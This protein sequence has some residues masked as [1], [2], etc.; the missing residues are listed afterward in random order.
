[1]EKI[2]MV[3]G[4]NLL[5]RSYYATAYTGNFMK[6]SKGFP[7]NALYGFINMINKIINEENPN[8]MIVAFDK[9][10]TFRHN[11]YKDYKG[12]RN[13]TPEELKLQFPIAKEI[14]TSM[15]IKYYEIDNYE[16][17]DI[18]GTFSSYCEKD[19][20]YEGL[21]VSSDKDLLQLVSDEV[22]IKL[23]KQKDFIKYNKT[24]FIEEYGIEP[25]KI[26]DL[27]ALMGD[28]S[29]SIPGVKGIGEKTA[30]KLL[31]DY[32]SLDG[33]YENIDKLTPKMQEKLLSEKEK[34]YLSFY[35][36]TIIK[37]VPMEIDIND[38]KIKEKDT[39]ELNQLYENLEFYSLLKKEKNEVKKDFSYKI[40]KDINMVSIDEPSSIYIELSGTNYHFSKILGIS[41]SNS[42][43][44]I[45]IPFEIFDK[46]ILNE[47]IK[48]TYDLKKLYVSLKNKNIIID[49]V[50][51]D[52]ML[53]AYLLEYN[54]KDDIAYLAN[55][56][57]FDVPFYDEIFKK[58][59]EN[60][61]QV[62]L[63]EIAS[64]ACKK[65]NFIYQT[66]NLLYDKLIIKELDH[67]FNNI[68]VPLSYVIGDMEYNGIFVNKNELTEMGIIFKEKI[69]NVEKNIFETAGTEFNVS[70]PKQL[71]EILFDKL[72]LAHGKKNKNGFSTSI[73][74]LE[75]L[76]NE[77]PIIEQIIEYRLLTKI[78]T[79]YIEGLKN[80][81]KEDN[82][83]HTIYTQTLTKTGRLSSIEPNLQNIPVRNEYGKIVRKAFVPSENS[84]IMSADYSQVELRILAS[85]ANID[86]LKEAFFS[87][88]DIHT[89]TAADIFKKDL[90]EVTSS[91][92]R[93]AKAVNFGIIYGI[94]KYGLSEN[95]GIKPYEAEEFINK[96]LETYPGIKE[97]MDE[98]I[99][100][101]YL[102][103]YV[104]TL[105]GRVRTIP[106]L[107][108]KNKNI[109]S[110]GERMALNTPI[111]GTSADLIKIAMVKTAEE[112]KKQNIKS[113]MIL[114]VHDELV[115][116]CLVEEIE[117]VTKIVEQTM[118]NAYKL[119]VPL[120]VDI[121][122]GKNWY[123]TK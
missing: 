59:K 69:D 75:K 40:V 6:N 114:Q 108:N 78:Y 38:I 68:E 39:Y 103:G 101:A 52:A 116:D 54:V 23:L 4:N 24:S 7:T 99:K 35:L 1:M 33:V 37:E 58:T 55:A 89:K 49:S 22:E 14:L 48:Y 72:N 18:I 29:D 34:A 119:D 43:E 70:S 28:P 82:K 117:K 46:K 17:D 109:K 36:A 77:H 111:Q 87:G 53:A 8:Y 45:Y 26:I 56:L 122:Y 106:E 107:F 112:F 86:S 118:E 21:I 2:I 84:V 97:Y 74:I 95:L 16:A 41:I 92:R 100:Q 13:E 88:I 104:K 113:K 31:Q 76:K 91:D 9:G 42:K 67:L 121:N 93:I 79:T 98:T 10:K 3:D 12:S 123:E 15:G 90:K 110:S 73:D 27:K 65:A 120:K 105:M 61:D 57:D 85:M 20:N 50:N 47:N 25:I 5:Y 30:L 60:D 115:F 62:L 64:S 66:K 44:N 102:D 63:E 32:K 19:S 80:Y 83:I 51:Y 71:G 11:E 96:Y 94:S 81:I